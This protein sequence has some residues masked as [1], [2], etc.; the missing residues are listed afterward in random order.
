MRY[1]ALTEH[2]IM[3]LWLFSTCNFRCGYCGLVTS[4]EVLNTNELTPYRDPAYIE[5]LL[6]F[7]RDNRPGGRPWAVMVHTTSFWPQSFGTFTLNM[8]C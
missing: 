8:N 4:G 3:E 2:N 6:R 1:R 7:F 5:Q